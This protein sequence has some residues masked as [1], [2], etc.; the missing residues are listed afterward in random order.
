MWE[1]E[2]LNN[3]LFVRV[4]VKQKGLLANRLTKGRERLQWD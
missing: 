1:R 2:N 3:C 4:V